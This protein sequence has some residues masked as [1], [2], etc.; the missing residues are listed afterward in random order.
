MITNDFEDSSPTATAA[1]IAGLRATFDNGGAIDV[2][3]ACALLSIEDATEND[4]RR[5]GQPASV[6]AKPAQT[7]PTRT[8]SPPATVTDADR[9]KVRAIRAR[10]NAADAKAALLDEISRK[11]GQAAAK[12]AQDL[13][14]DALVK[15][16]AAPSREAIAESWTRALQRAGAT[17][18]TAPTNGPKAAAQSNSW[19]RVWLSKGFELDPSAGRRPAALHTA[20]I[21]A[22]SPR[23]R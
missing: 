6:T 17:V 18:Q 15:R 23:G 14:I 5:A 11:H 10:V 12:A 22:P 2:V 19:D 1:E 3:A 16:A 21:V 9:A 4:R 20:G 7:A 13:S 8:A